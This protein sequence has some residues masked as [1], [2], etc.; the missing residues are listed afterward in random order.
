VGERLDSNEVGELLDRDAAE[1]AFQRALHF[2]AARPRSAFEVRR[3]L[4]AAGVEDQLASEVIDRLRRQ[5]LLDDAQFAAYW[6]EQRQAFKPRGPRALRS[7]LRAKGIAAET[8]IPA[9]RAAAED[10]G[11]AACRAGLREARRRCAYDEIEFT[12]A[13]GKY[14]ARRGF[15]YGVT[16]AAVAEL[17]LLM[18]S[19]AAGKA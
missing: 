12:Q 1:R 16:R 13:L 9:I 17:W 2:L 19:E 7:E 10:Q 6:V 8:M 14:L 11:D 5:G 18:Q 15:D 4:R 3:R